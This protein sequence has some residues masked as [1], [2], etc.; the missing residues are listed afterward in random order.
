MNSSVNT[1]DPD[2][3]VQEVVFPPETGG[4][5]VNKIDPPFVIGHKLQN[6]GAQGINISMVESDEK[7]LLAYHLPHQDMDRGERVEVKLGGTVVANIN[8]KDEH[9]DDQ[10]NAKPIP[11]NISIDDM[12]S[13]FPPLQPQNVKCQSEVFRLSGNSEKSPETD[14]CF[15]NPKPGE[16]DT[17]HAEPHNQGLGLVECSETIIDKTVVEE[18]LTLTAPEY[19][20][21]NIGD[22]RTITLGPL[23]WEIENTT[24]GGA[25]DI[26]VTPEELATL[27]A[28]DKLLARWMVRDRVHNFSG[29]SG[30]LSI[31]FKPL[32]KLLTP[33]II[34][35]AD[36][37]N[38]VHHDQ[39]NGSSLP[40]LVTGV[41]A[42]GQI[43]NLTIK[44]FTKTGEAVSHTYSR[45]VASASRTEVFDMEDWRV[46]NLIGGN[47]EATYEWIKGGVSQHSKPASATVSGV[48]QPLAAPTATPQ[49][50]GV[51]RVDA[52]LVEVRCAEYWPLVKG[53]RVELS[54]QTED[55][56]GV[57]TLF[58][59]RQPIVD[60][61]REIVFNVTPKYFAQ[62][63]DSELVLQCSITNPG[64]PTVVS[65]LSELKIG[66]YK[67][68]TLT[69]PKL[70]E[71]Q[72]LNPLGAE[73][74]VEAEFPGATTEHRARLVQ[75]DAPANSPD[76][77]IKPFDKDKRATWKLDRNFL[78][79]NH[80]T[81]FKMHWNLRFKG[82]RVASSPTEEITIAPIPDYSNNFPTPTIDGVQGI[83]EVKK[84]TAANL[85]RVPPWPGQAPGQARFLRF[86]GTHKNGTQVSYQ[87]L[88]GQVTGAEQG[89]TTALILA[90]F[91]D[92]KD[93]T[94]LNISFSVI[95]GPGQKP[96][97]FPKQT[98]RVESLD[99]RQPVISNVQAPQ[100]EVP[101]NTETI[102]TAL[103][104]YCRGT[105]DENIEILSNGVVHNVA[106]TNSAGIA[107]GVQVTVS[108]YDAYNTIVARAQYGNK[109]SSPARSVILR[110]PLY[111]DTTRR[112]LN[113]VVCH[114]GWGQ[115]GAR[116][117]GN[118]LQL[119]PL[120]GVGQRT[121]SS[122]NPAVVSVDANGLVTGRSWGAAYIYIQDRFTTHAIYVDSI[123]I[124]RLV[125]SGGAGTSHQ[126]AV[127][128]M[129]SIGG[130]PINAAWSGMTT[131]YGPTTN[132]P[133]WQHA[134]HWMCEGAGCPAG[135]GQAYHHNNKGILCSPAGAY[136]WQAWCM[137]RA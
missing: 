4:I 112:L 36:E 1:P 120:Y 31:I 77:G 130:V 40:I 63:P 12:Y 79:R 69:P 52:A 3:P 75:T 100:G 90:W 95:L 126:G 62:F 2:S 26:D 104:I 24:P 6:D 128:W 107:P 9:F 56:E 37:N 13:T 38:V 5:R 99:E 83:V 60:P 45:T 74:T 66:L 136:P 59:F 131:V 122:S 61:T 114:T 98:Y 103:T 84:L 57:P 25:I 21:S 33:P 110:R 50:E 18:G 135:H 87:A 44:G 23:R 88:N 72:P 137:V 118:W 102:S 111:I 106:R 58:V 94:A 10:G 43:I 67:D 105:P 71:P 76:L 19:F 29:W 123:N 27:P 125:A 22:V 35:L 42:I 20:N 129:N 55:K 32:V 48:A 53:A 108:N 82:E 117:P 81:T 134:V 115:T 96:L 47:F 34:E 17:D 8:I 15:L 49:I 133:L 132:W 51:I 64:K 101:H 11:Y 124:Y 127:N 97:L 80:G 30:A 121:F 41:F 68:A 91:L 116:W 46:Q 93:E 65:D 85:L 14:L 86:E 39:L 78:I 70:L 7:G 113:G 73:A 92:L 28:T 54:W 89:S 119:S 16:P 109:L